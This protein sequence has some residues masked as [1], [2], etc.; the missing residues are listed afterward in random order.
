MEMKRVSGFMFE[1]PLLRRDLFF[2]LKSK[3]EDIALTAFRRL[4][5]VS[6]SIISDL[7]ISTDL[8]GDNSR[9][10]AEIAVEM[11][12]VLNYNKFDPS[13]A[14]KVFYIL[15]TCNHRP[16][17]L[18]WTQFDWSVVPIQ[19]CS[20][21]LFTIFMLDLSPPVHVLKLLATGAAESS[22]SDCAIAILSLASLPGGIT[23][24]GITGVGKLVKGLVNLNEIDKRQ[25][26]K[27]IALLK[28]RPDVAELIQP[29]QGTPGSPPV[30]TSRLHNEV[31]RCVR[32]VTGRETV[33]EM[34][35]EEMSSFIDIVV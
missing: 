28:D 32:K 24:V 23:A 27:A 15:K 29:F 9:V 26:S 19:K 10:I 1:R 8:S 13:D 21:I 5:A 7:V 22:G 34:P 31:E 11:D 25:I 14:E 33:R 4:R 3:D 18:P 20:N 35:I 16:D 12:N 17:K 6:P 2:L 30:N